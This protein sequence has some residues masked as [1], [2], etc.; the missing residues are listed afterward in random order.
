VLA[1]LEKAAVDDERVVAHGH[2][3]YTWHPAG[4]ARSKMWTAIAGTGL[5]VTATARN[6]RTVTTLLE[7]AG[8]A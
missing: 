1:R 3:L 7:M 8:G 5:G 6:W 4:V 2:E